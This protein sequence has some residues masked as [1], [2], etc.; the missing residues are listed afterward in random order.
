MNFLRGNG[1]DSRKMVRR[2]TG[3]LLAGEAV[4]TGL[5]FGVYAILGKMNGKVLLGGL[6]GV[7]LAVLNFSMMA[8]GANAA[9][10]R[11]VNMEDTTS[12]KSLMTFSYIIRLAVIFIV[13]LI[14][15]KAGLCEPIASILPLIFVQPILLISEFVRKKDM[16]NGKGDA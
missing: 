8:A 5:M 3:I 11:A 14:C 7:V 2:T 6:L 13:L 9:A 15:V 1:M 10:D 12:G 4:C 16:K